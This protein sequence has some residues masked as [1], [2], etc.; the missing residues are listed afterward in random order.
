MMLHIITPSVDS[1]K[2]LKRLDTQPYQRTYQNLIK[3]SKVVEK[4]ETFLRN[5][6]PNVPSLPDFYYYNLSFNLQT[7]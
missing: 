1:K 4:K 5:K 2:W 6:Q 3:H 7:V